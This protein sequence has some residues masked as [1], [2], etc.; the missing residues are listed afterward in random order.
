ML[1]SVCATQS[2]MHPCIFSCVCY[3]HFGNRPPCW[4]RNVLGGEAGSWPSLKHHRQC[5]AV[6]AVEDSSR[7]TGGLCVMLASVVVT[8]TT[9]IA[10]PPTS[11]ASKR[12]QQ[13]CKKVAA[14]LV[15]A[16]ERARS[17]NRASRDMACK[18]QAASHRIEIASRL[19]FWCLTIM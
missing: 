6:F 17:S 9:P 12:L 1:K 8:E 10:S 3:R 5:D 16:I 4:P 14:S 15:T 2:P 7:R 19:Y 18:H 13:R 11:M